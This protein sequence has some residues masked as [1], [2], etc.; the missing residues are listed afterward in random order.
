MRESRMP[1]RSA[2]I[3]QKSSVRPSLIVRLKVPAAYFIDFIY[4]FNGPMRPT[5]NKVPL[6]A[7]IANM[8]NR[9][10]PWDSAPSTSSLA[11]KSWLDLDP[12]KPFTRTGAESFP[13]PA[14]QEDVHTYEVR[15]V[16]EDSQNLSPEKDEPE[17]SFRAVE[18]ALEILANPREPWAKPFAQP[19]PTLYTLKA[20]SERDAELVIKPETHAKAS[21]QSRP[22]NLPK[23]AP[24]PKKASSSRIALESDRI[25]R[26]QLTAELSTKPELPAS[27]RAKTEPETNTRAKTSEDGGFGG[28]MEMR[29]GINA[30]NRR[31]ENLPVGEGHVAGERKRKGWVRKA[32]PTEGDGEIVV[33]WTRGRTRPG[34]G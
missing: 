33:A 27:H 16:E 5:F 6:R 14:Q 32:L 4:N 8:T 13:Q 15:R 34:I 10:H 12:Q 28:E 2:G 25:L 9:L 22:A 18:G 20:R 23:L 1:T 24:I 31:E 7:P 3:S 11:P 17:P 29:M 19:S 21:P 30:Q 26:S